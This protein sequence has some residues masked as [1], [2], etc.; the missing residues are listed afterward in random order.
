MNGT[1]GTDHGVGGVA[2]LLG[3]AV[4]GGQVVSD[5]TGLDRKHLFEG[6]DLMPTIDQRRV[7]KAVLTEHMGADPALVEEMAFPDSRDVKPLAGL[8]K[9]KAPGNHVGD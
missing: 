9:T 2:F 3:G 8:F 6:R 7:F 5:W 4:K 1:R